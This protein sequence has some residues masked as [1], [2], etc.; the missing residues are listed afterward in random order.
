[1]TQARRILLIRHT[2]PNID[3]DVC[4][5]SSDI[6]LINSYQHE[7]LQIA[8]KCQDFKPD[9]IYTSP[10]KRCYQLAV[11]LFIN[12]HI[13]IDERL[14]EMHFGDWELMRWTDIPADEMDH[15]SNNFY[16]VPTPK[17]ESFKELHLRVLEMWNDLIA[18]DPSSNIVIV[19]HS[20]VM[21]IILMHLLHI[22]YN[23]IF[24]LTLNYGA[25]VEVK[26]QDEVMYNVHFR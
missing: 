4:Y 23:K 3:K 13:C 19:S 18:N 2:T 6:D 8:N 21:R 10:L 24:H 15:W 11:D 20:G 16:E 7:K 5:G 9:I 22:P 26:W 17:G 12:Q 1:M 14:K 25:V